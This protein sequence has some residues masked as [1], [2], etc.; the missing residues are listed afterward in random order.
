MFSSYLR[1]FCGA[2][3]EISPPNCR[4]IPDI[5]RA[6]EFSGFISIMFSSLRA[7]A[8]VVIGSGLSLDTAVELSGQ[9][10]EDCR[11]G[12]AAFRLKGVVARGLDDALPEDAHELINNRKGAV[13]VGVTQLFPTPKGV[14]VSKFDSKADLIEVVL[15]SCH[16]PFWLS[17]WPYMQV[18]GKATVDGFFSMPRGK[19]GA[20]AI[21]TADEIVRISVFP[22]TSIK[23]DSDKPGD[24]ISPDLLDRY[25]SGRFAELLT[26]AVNPASELV[27]EE[28]FKAG[29]ESAGVWCDRFGEDYKRRHERKYS[30]EMVESSTASSHH[31]GVSLS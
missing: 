14:F 15:G 3:V 21:P 29:F 22:T 12:G 31:G 9:V 4:N 11:E 18:R 6:G 16:V 8:A 10:F 24:L 13:T 2:D 25:R 7:L 27:M 26:Y 5:A 28:L 19:F 20:P 1:L 30:G 17:G 23:I